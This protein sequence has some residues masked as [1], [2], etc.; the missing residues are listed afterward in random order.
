MTHAIT[1][2]A[3]PADKLDR[4][5]VYESLSRLSHEMNAKKTVVIE[6]NQAES[7]ARVALL[8]EPVGDHPKR[9]GPRRRRIKAGVGKRTASHSEY[10]RRSG[11]G[12]KKKR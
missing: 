9:V 4:S 5:R 3:R 6:L 11:R 7:D 1:I 2:D 10:F 8:P 12:I